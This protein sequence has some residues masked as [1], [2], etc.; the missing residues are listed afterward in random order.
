MTSVI[1]PSTT[2]VRLRPEIAALPAYKQGKPAVVGGHKLSSNENPYPPLPGLLA[3]I[4]AA[5]AVNRYPDAAATELRAALAAR[6]GVSTDEVHVGAGSVSILSQLITAAAGHGDEVVYAWRAFEAYPGLVTVAGADSV[7][8]PLRADGSH[9]LDA[10]ADAVTSRTRAVL[11]CSPNN[12]T[13]V[14]VSRDAFVRFMGRVPSDLLVLLDEAYVEFIRNSD[15]VN[16]RE[17][18][19]RYPN[20]V[21]LRTFSKAWGLAGVRLGYAIGPA[22]I[23]DAARATAIPLSV[24]AAAQAAGLAAL[25]HEK[26]LL[27]RVD[28]IVRRRVTVVNRLRELGLAIPESEGNFIWL[29]LGDETDT[30]ATILERHS[31]VAR[32]FSGDGIRVS[33]G[34]Q[35]SVEGLLSAAEEIVR[36]LPKTVGAAG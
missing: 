34:E 27:E 11:V 15:A 36:N 10:M 23:L 4:M 17:L 28:D 13:G 26:V 22:V 3:A 21:I 5:D 16:G 32:V 2:P 29:P 9:D 8:V 25:E 18:L 33:I 30:A 6:H 35:E 24:T 20:L 7:R 19:G 1:E 31:I 14:V 12:P